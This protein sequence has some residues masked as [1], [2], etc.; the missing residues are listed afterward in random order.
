MID[1]K[2]HTIMFDAPISEALEKLNLP[3][4]LKTVFVIDQ[5]NQVIGTITDGDIRRGL[6]N[7]INFSENCEK[8]AFKDFKFLQDGNF[9]IEQ[10]ILWRE[11]QIYILPLLNKQH[12]LIEILNFNELKSF[13][14]LTAV[15]MAGG[16]GNRLRPLTQN[17]PKPMLKIGDIP[18]LEI[19]IK[20][21]IQFGIRDI[22]LCVNYLKEQ[23]I[24]HFGNG[25]KWNCNITYIEENQPL[26]TIGALSLIEK[27][28]HQQVL[29]FNADLLSNIDFED[30]YCKFLQHHSQLSIASIPHKI[31]LPYAVLEGQNHQITSIS[32]KPTYTYFANAGFYLFDS[33]LVNRI[34]K[35]EF[36]NATDFVEDLLQNNFT[37]SSFPI[38]GY[39]SDIGSI[40]DYKKSCEDFPNLNFF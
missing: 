12:E 23:I 16:F 1:I 25:E 8:F 17:T 19:N 13:L 40:D 35:N 27:I 29:L 22:I 18:I 21:L 10:L 6:L 14:P 37:V 39:W 5:N 2:S 24:D 20:R 33:E 31:T 9:S 34:P 38:H 28:K 15:I 7:G 4:H 36:Y 11:R 30:M 26:G 32:E 3:Y